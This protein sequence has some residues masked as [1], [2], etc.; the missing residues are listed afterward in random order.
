MIFNS[1]FVIWL[2]WHLDLG[3]KVNREPLFIILYIKFGRNRFTWSPAK[4]SGSSCLVKASLNTEIC[5]LL[6][7]T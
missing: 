3:N 2:C 6:F 1:I 7:F 5:V 4:I